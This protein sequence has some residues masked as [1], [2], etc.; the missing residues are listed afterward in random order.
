VLVLFCKQLPVYVFLA[1]D[2]FIVLTQVIFVFTKSQL[3]VFHV[4]HESVVLPYRVI[5]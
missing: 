4:H 2:K 3:K 5:L 1:P